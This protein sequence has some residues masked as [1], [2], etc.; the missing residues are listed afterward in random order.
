MIQNHFVGFSPTIIKGH[1]LQILVGA[2]AILAAGLL[3]LKQLYCGRNRQFVNGN[4]N[5]YNPPVVSF[6]PQLK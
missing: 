3:V 1:A 4:C 5:N 6:T 2:D